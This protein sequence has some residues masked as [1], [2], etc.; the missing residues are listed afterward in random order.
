MIVILMYVEM[1]LRVHRITND[2]N[3]TK[4]YTILISE[5]EAREGYI[6]PRGNILHLLGLWL[7]LSVF[8]FLSIRA[9]IPS[10]GW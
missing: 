10:R 4:C 8:Y 6:I 9:R 1:M 3:S 5:S 7:R 2:W